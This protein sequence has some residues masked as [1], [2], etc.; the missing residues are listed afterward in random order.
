M[1]RTDFRAE[2]PS[3]LTPWTIGSGRIEQ[4]HGIRFV[5][6]P[7]PAS[8]YSDAQISD[9]AGLSRRAYPW[10][11]PMR[12]TVRAWASH[13]AD[14]LR[15]TAGFG[16][17]NQPFM[18]GQTWPRLPRTAWFFFGSKPSNMAL[19]YGVPGYGWKAATLDATRPPFLAL[20]PSA[21]IGVL[22]MRVPAL[23]RVLYPLAQRAIGVSEALISADLRE[24]HTYQMEW[25]PHSL[26]FSVDGRVLLR[27]PS[28]PR[29]RLGFIAWLD[30]QYAVVTPQGALGMGIA[31]ILETQWL[32]LDS[33]L[34]EPL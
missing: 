4:A 2:L 20:S 27:T 34:I 31:D 24:P 17:W 6:N 15:G 7:T 33:L 1:I 18:P 11:P 16:L 28:A 12:M 13:S 22:L 9:Y 25:Q 30:N 3:T 8:H 21:P 5:I 19:A 14:Q 10:S 32:H 29:G 23:Y 26:T